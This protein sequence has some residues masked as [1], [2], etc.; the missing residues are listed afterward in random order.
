VGSKPL[1][2]TKRTSLKN[3]PKIFEKLGLFFRGGLVLGLETTTQRIP[4]PQET[5]PG[6]GGFLPSA[7]F[8][9]VENM[10]VKQ[11]LLDQNQAHSFSIALQFIKV[12]II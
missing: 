2:L 5:P 10:L 11:R 8:D 3:N 9:L 6:G 4:L 7:Y 12:S 1:I